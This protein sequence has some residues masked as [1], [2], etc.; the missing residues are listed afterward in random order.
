MNN[1]YVV[2]LPIGNLDDITLRAIQTLKD[3]DF[4]YSEK[5]LKTLKLLNHFEIKK[6]VFIYSQNPSPHLI[7]QFLEKLSKGSIALVVEAGTPGISDPG[8][9]LIHDL[10]INNSDL[11]IMPIPGVSALTTSLSVSG[12]NTQEFIF[13]G[14]YPK[15]KKTKF[16]EKINANK[17]V[18]FY[19]SCH[20]ILKT[21]KEIS[22]KTNK[23]NIV[24][25]RE[26]TKLHEEVIRCKLQDLPDIIEKINPKGEFTIILN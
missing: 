1:I 3:V 8:N 24:I 19:E 15:T 13:L 10:L 7:N 2:G 6:S 5:P 20:R 25:C 26:L 18:V 14:F 4:I 17:T 16:I 11:N 21:L 22:Q 23:E 12:L 9:K